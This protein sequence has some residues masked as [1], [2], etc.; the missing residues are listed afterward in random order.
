MAGI[1]I[2]LA[3]ALPIACAVVPLHA[4]ALQSAPL[5]QRSVSVDNAMDFHEL[6]RRALAEVPYIKKMEIRDALLKVDGYDAQGMKVKI[7]MDRR[8]GGVLSREIKYD[9]HGPFGRD[10]WRFQQGMQSG[11]PMPPPGR[12]GQGAAPATFP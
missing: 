2:A 9:K 7:Y 11:Y 12:R 8:S 10:G 4:A 3:I 1:R 6:E 5:M